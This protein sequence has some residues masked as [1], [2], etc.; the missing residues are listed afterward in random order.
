M[1]CRGDLELGRSVE[2]PS[3]VSLTCVGPAC[4]VGVS[5]PHPSLSFPQEL[6]K[7]GFMYGSKLG[8]Q[9]TR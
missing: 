6:S 4:R 3:E 8:T 7:Y 5:S 1:I 2:L 9:L